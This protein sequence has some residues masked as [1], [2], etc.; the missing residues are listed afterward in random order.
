MEPGS[1][2]RTMQRA[3]NDHQF[4]R[5][6][7]YIYVLNNRQKMVS[8]ESLLECV[9][10]IYQPCQRQFVAH[11]S[12]RVRLNDGATLIISKVRRAKSG[13]QICQLNINM[14][15][16]H[17]EIRAVS[18]RTF[19]RVIGIITSGQTTM[20]QSVDYCMEILFFENIRNIKHIVKSRVTDVEKRTLLR[21]QLRATSDFLE[22]G[23]DTH[24][25]QED[26]SVHNTRLSLMGNE[27]PTAMGTP[28]IVGNE[29][30]ERA[31]LDPAD[32]CVQCLKP[33]QVTEDV[34]A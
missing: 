27:L 4:F 23:Y 33:F 19:M 20:K 6:H 17:P 13:T 1:F 31:I 5:E 24:L 15:K 29:S 14:K 12:K 26:I 10:F 25:E 32:T 7:G 34:R 30:N 28:E 18:K 3:R 9:K 11:G 21:N 2:R 8:D 22:H 16:R